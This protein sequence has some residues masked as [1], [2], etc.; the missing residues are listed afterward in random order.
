MMTTVPGPKNAALGPE[1][2][3][4]VRSIV[5]AWGSDEVVKVPDPATS[6]TWLREELRLVESAARSGAPIAAGHHLVELESG[7]QGLVSARVD[8]PSMWQILE[9]TP[10][11]AAEMGAELARLQLALFVLTPSYE[12]P[13]QHDRLSS[14]IRRAARDHGDDLLGVLDLIVGTDGPM[15]LCH[16]DLHPRNVIL[17]PDG[18]VIVD[19]FDAC[20]GQTIAEVARTSVMLTSREFVPGGTEMSNDFVATITAMHD[21]YRVTIDQSIQIDTDEL[22]RWCLVHTVARLAEGFGTERLRDLR[23]ALAAGAT[24]PGWS[25]PTP[26]TTTST[27]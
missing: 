20:R 13:D 9:R 16:G 11:R 10:E 12:L 18:P 14:K 1:I 24:S 22:D 25:W 3:R 27:C 6:T 21:A 7:R 4:G 5:Y 8:G 17:S 19:W 23:T 15:V 26:T 2:G